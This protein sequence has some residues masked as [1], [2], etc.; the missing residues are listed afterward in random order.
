MRRTEQV[1]SVLIKELAP[2]ID[3]KLGEQFGIVTLVDALVTP[4]L[5]EAKVYVSCFDKNNEKQVL[6]VLEKTTPV[7]QKH[8]GKRLKMKFTPKISFYLDN[9][10]E[11]VIKVEQLLDDVSKKDS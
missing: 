1:A 3:E 11:N 7:F 10:L 9:S 6:R 5:K 2:L 8:L 4:D